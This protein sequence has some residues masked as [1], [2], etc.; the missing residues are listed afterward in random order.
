M[1]VNAIRENKVLVKFFQIYSTV[2]EGVWG[3]VRALKNAAIS[4]HCITD[5][6][7]LLLLSVLYL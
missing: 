5:S 7:N 6:S 2:T 3:K 4:Q 1:S